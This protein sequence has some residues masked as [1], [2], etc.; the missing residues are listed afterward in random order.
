MCRLRSAAAAATSSGSLTYRTCNRAFVSSAT[1]AAYSSACRE[2]SEKSIGQSTDWKPAHC[3]LPITS[4]PLC[5]GA[6]LRRRS[7]VGSPLGFELRHHRV[8]SAHL[9]DIAPPERLGRDAH[10]P[11]SHSSCHHSFLI[12]TASIGG[13]ARDVPVP[14]GLT[15]DRSSG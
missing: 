1:T 7:L 11:F 6:R 15:F 3:L 4:R 10:H 9:E 13:F 2:S 8:D 12:V 5:S 14:R